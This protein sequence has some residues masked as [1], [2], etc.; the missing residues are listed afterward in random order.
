MFQDWARHATR[1]A[2]PARA[3]ALTRRPRRLLDAARRPQREQRGCCRCL[4]APPPRAAA[5]ERRACILR[6]RCDASAG[7]PARAR[8]TSRVARRRA[9][10]RYE[11]TIAREV[12]PVAQGARA[13]VRAPLHAGGPVRLEEVPP[14]RAGGNE[15]PL[16]CA[17]RP[18]GR[19]LTTLA[20]QGSDYLSVLLR[21]RRLPAAQR[22]LGRAPPGAAPPPT[23]SA[24]SLPRE[25]GQS[26]PR[27]AAG[28]TRAV[29]SGSRG[30]LRS[31]RPA[32]RA[33]RGTKF[34]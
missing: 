27:T 33:G 7:A 2:S 21:I 12:C 17:E 31:G 6:R 23:A 9:A 16:L 25:R 34:D 32:R 28:Q 8:V 4:L 11:P 3:R 10:R 29:G 13:E 1:E 5:A 19:S 26:R 18:R 22:R 20:L 14:G 30:A 24:A 15:R